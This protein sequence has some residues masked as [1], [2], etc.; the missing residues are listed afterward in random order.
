M[1]KNACDYTKFVVIG[2]VVI[3]A[4]LVI[5]QLMKKNSEGFRMVQNDLSNTVGRYAMA[6]PNLA[7]LPVSPRSYPGLNGQSLSGTPPNAMILPPQ[8]TYTEGFYPQF[9][10]QEGFALPGDATGITAGPTVDFA[11][12]GGGFGGASDLPA[13]ALTSSQ[14]QDMLQQQ[15]NGGTPQMPEVSL[16]LAN[17]EHSTDPT[18]PQNFMY[19]RTVFAPLKRQYGNQVDFIRGDIDVKQEFRGWFDARPATDKDIVTGYFDRFLDIQQQASLKDAQFN[20]STP[21][22]NL[23]NSSISP[24]NMQLTAY[25]NI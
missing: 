6:P 12:M 9:S 1:A 4:V 2:L 21:V 11:T 25:A 7:A 18:D 17:I 20:R 3:I 14:A 16:P 23:F 22:E 5:M 8:P 10:Q 13:G 24:A 15:M 19:D